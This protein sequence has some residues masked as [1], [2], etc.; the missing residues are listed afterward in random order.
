MNK[1]LRVAAALAAALSLLYFA[2]SAVNGESPLTKTFNRIYEEG[3]WGR[4]VAGKGTSGSGSS[5]E[6]TRDYRAYLEEFIRTQRVRSI[7][8][9]GCGDWTFSSAIDWGGASYL[10][11]DVA[12]DVI[13]ANRRKYEKRNVTFRVGD[14]TEELPAADLL[15]S[16]D[17]LQHL[18]D[19]LVDK[20]IRNNLKK[21]KYKWVLL[22][23]DRGTGNPDIVPGGYR[24]IDLAAAPFNVTGLVDLPI[25]FGNEVTKTTSLLDLSTGRNAGSRGR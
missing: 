10:G 14:I 12:S 20:F 15:I 1:R 6:I 3:V 7:V 16:K 22:T 18:P 21:G 4:D 13:E 23:N 11:V 24:A 19:A 17:V 25:K 5:L 2:I 9:A 8:D